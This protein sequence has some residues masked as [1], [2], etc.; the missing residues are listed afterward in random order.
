MPSSLELWVLVAGS[1]VGALVFGVSGFAFSLSASVIWL[2]WLPPAEVVPLAVIVPIVLNLVTLPRIWRDVDLG[3]VWPFAAGATV[4]APLGVLLLA[5]FDPSGLRLAIGVALVAY[6][7]FALCR[8]ALPTLDLPARAARIG[9]GA[10][11]LVG[12]VF[13]GIAGLSVVLPSLWIG[14]RGF[15]KAQQRGVLQS[16]GFYSQGLTLVLYTSMIGFG[17][18]TGRA[19]LVCLPIA[20]V[21]SLAG[22]AIF[23]RLSREAFRRAILAIV[24][25]GGVALLVR[26]LR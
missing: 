8:P 25:C 3:K 14:M 11:G 18:R 21:G 19:L 22:M 15:A 10:V 16:F 2:Q 5:R 1:A 9:D 23:T 6:S 20:V 4:G 12:G 7:A 26:G 13:G 17:G 24:L